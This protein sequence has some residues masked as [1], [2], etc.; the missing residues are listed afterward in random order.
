MRL[1]RNQINMRGL[2]PGDRLPSIRQLA[3]QQ[4]VAASTVVEA[5]ERL[6]AE[7]LIRA[8][9]GSGFYVS[10]QL[11]L[12]LAVAS[13][14]GPG[15]RVVDPFW[16]ARQSLD[17]DP[18]ALKPGCGWLPSD[19]LPTAAL[20]SAMRQLARA[21]DMLLSDYGST[22]GSFNLRRLLLQRFAAE[23]LEVSPE[24]LLLSASGTQAI[25]LVCRFLLRPG[26]TVMLDDPCY[27]NFRAL[28]RAHQVNVIGVPYTHAGP[29]LA[30]FAGLLEQQPVRLYITNSALHN[31]TGAT[32]NASHA[33]QLLSL[34]A[35]HE[36]TIVEDDIFSDFEPEPSV[37]LSTLDGLQRVIRIGS[38]SKTLSAAVRCGYIACR[39]DW[40][41][42]LLDLQLA[43]G[44]GGPS[45]MAAELIAGVLAGGAYRK[46]MEHLRR[47]LAHQRSQVAA[48]LLQ[49]QIRPRL[50]PRG[51][52][53]LWCELPPGCDSAR[54]AEQALAQKVVL[55]PGN[56]FS[57]S[58]SA[59]G[60]MRFNVA[61]C[62]DARLFS[63]LAELIACARTGS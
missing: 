36:L 56:V 11:A 63:L 19:W 40:L 1:I 44:F 59:A 15:E 39:P 31:P 58:Q 61:H 21:D 33:H 6:A 12:P 4:S 16:V 10:S 57:V 54:F 34:A 43:T 62:N 22:R 3:K 2:L 60:M 13:D 32:I 30:R 5:Y 53:Y 28:L 20:R 52:F 51:G 14:P 35:R 42:G 48:Q 45:P 26:D 8:R 27:F 50:M 25:D 7:G 37:R 24:Q 41:K 46:Q 17:A 49:L 23:G 38:F 18:G 55:A 47:R 29:D 9:A